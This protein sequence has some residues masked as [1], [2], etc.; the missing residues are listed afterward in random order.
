[1]L[2]ESLILGDANRRR[3]TVLS[4][5]PRIWLPRDDFPD[6]GG[7]CADD[8][9]SNVLGA[10]GEVGH[11]FDDNPYCMRGHGD[12]RL[13]NLEELL[14]LDSLPLEETSGHPWK[15]GDDA[16][17]SEAYDALGDDLL[18]RMEMWAHVECVRNASNR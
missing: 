18:Y 6:G 16:L 8:V 13:A 14:L 4:Q 12:G 9:I 5:N 11:P 1:M 10:N 7:I 15:P 17:Q 3:V 2:G